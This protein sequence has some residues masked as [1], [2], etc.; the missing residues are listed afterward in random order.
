MQLK[1]EG[2]NGDDKMIKP[3]AS[4]GKTKE[5]KNKVKRY[6]CHREKHNGESWGQLGSQGLLIELSPTALYKLCL[7]LMSLINDLI[8]KQD[9]MRYCHLQTSN[10]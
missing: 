9:Q 5:S 10:Q 2:E 1:L 4:W 6:Q 7:C 8:S 3:A